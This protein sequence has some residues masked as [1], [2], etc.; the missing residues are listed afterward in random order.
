MSDPE[1]PMAT[2]AR[3]QPPSVSGRPPIRSGR[4]FARRWIGRLV[5]WVPV[6][7]LGAAAAARVLKLQFWPVELLWHFTQTFFII[8]V[9]LTV[10]L[11]ALRLFAPAAAA[12]ALAVFFAMS[13]HAVPGDATGQQDSLLPAAAARASEVL[14]PQDSAFTLVTHNLYVHND[15]RDDLAAWLRRQDADVIVLQEVK[16]EMAAVLA[17]A[18]D[19]Y[20]EQFFAWPEYYE[21]KPKL[22]DQLSGLA[23]LSRYP[24]SDP[25]MFLRT[26]YSAPVAIAELA[27]PDGPRVRLV[28]VHGSNPVRRSGLRARNALMA[29]LPEELARYKEPIVMAGDF[30]ATPYTPAFVQFLL[31]AHLT[32]SRAYPGTYPQFAGSFG[33]PIDHVLVRDARIVDITALD[34]FGSDHRPLR[35]DLIVPGGAKGE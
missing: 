15:R 18:K 2:A 21:E 11:L 12:A 4:S 7:G 24:L 10:A 33:L 16:T 26:K 32:A 20:P 30:N 34:A 3:P 35:A 13:A 19:L 5:P 9:A 8:S 17:A 1:T 6:I 22:R 29:A 27:L 31:A 25:T 28:V 14:A 23:I